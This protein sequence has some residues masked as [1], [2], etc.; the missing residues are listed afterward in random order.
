MGKNDEKVMS[1]TGHLEELRRVLIISIAAIFVLG[2]V[3]YVFSDELMAVF[4][5]P[6]TSAGYK[7]VVTYV[8]EAFMTKIKLS[9][10]MGFLAALP[11]L[12]WQLWSFIAPALEKPTRRYLVVFVMGSF[13]L[14]VGGVVFGF[15]GV[16]KYG[17]AFLLRFAGANI[18][19]MLTLGKYISF[20][21][22]FLLPFGIIFEL[23]LVSFVLARLGLISSAFLSKN[24]KYAVL[25]TIILAAAITP[26]PDAITCLLMTGPMYALYEMS[27]LIVRFTERAVARRK[28]KEEAEEAEA[29]Q[30]AAP[31]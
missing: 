26:T 29:V 24:R 18:V 16:Y 12:L 31:S 6:V 25:V 28:A 23:P 20:T 5:S 10:F 3:S 11:I 27:V 30:E 7:P 21:I 1:I 22:W 4:L 17:V 19:P 8:T 14:F 2:I 9:F 15:F 13:V